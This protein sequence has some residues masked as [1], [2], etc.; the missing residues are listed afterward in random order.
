MTAISPPF[1]RPFGTYI[2]PQFPGVKGRAIFG[3]VPAGTKN[4]TALRRGPEGGRLKLSGYFPNR[5]S[6]GIRIM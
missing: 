4:K 6:S 3:N 1:N 5:F 2:T